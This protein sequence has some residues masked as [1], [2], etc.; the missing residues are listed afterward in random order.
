LDQESESDELEFLEDDPEAMMAVLRHI[1][2]LPYATDAEFDK[3]TSLLPHA[4]VYTTAEKYQIH[5]L[6]IESCSAM[7][8]ILLKNS[9]PKEHALEWLCSPD[10]LRALREVINGTPKSDLAGRDFLISHCIHLMPG[11]NDNQAFMDLVADL[12]GL[13]A[14]LITNIYNGK[15]HDSGADYASAKDVSEE[16]ESESEGEGSKKVKSEDAD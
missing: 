11:L 8:D 10:Q 9:E 16:E 5:G 1:Y 12:P 7:S 4:M 13:G 3:T 15:D 14:D 6:K 2:G